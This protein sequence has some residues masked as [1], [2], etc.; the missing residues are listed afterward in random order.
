MG[1]HN[2]SGTGLPG[3]VTITGQ[4][5]KGDQ[6]GHSA[7]SGSDYRCESPG[8]EGPYAWPRDLIQTGV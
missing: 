6:L 5:R 3:L 4:V 7:E 2:T 8:L 1:H